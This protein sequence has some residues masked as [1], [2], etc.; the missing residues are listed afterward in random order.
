MGSLWRL[1]ISIRACHGAGLILHRLYA[2]RYRFESNKRCGSLFRSRELRSINEGGH[3]VEQGPSLFRTEP[4]PH[5]MESHRVS[6]DLGVR[7]QQ[8]G[9]TLTVGL[10]KP[11]QLRG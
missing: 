11:C 1:R 8:S 3:D 7:A 5:R 2:N 6:H 10:S 4:N 9:K